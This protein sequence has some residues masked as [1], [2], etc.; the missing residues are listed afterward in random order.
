MHRSELR[1]WA[2]PDGR[3]FTVQAAP[4]PPTITSF[5][6]RTGS[7]GGGTVVAIT[8]TNFQNGATVK[9]GDASA[10][11][12][13]VNSATSINAISP[14]H[15]AGDVNLTVTNP[16]GQ[17][18]SSGT[19]TYTTPAPSVASVSPSSG[20]NAGGTG[21]TVTGSNFVSPTT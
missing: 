11:S 1:Y 19:F 4:T 7:T 10:V 6:P 9:F 5:T 13:T 3:T 17:T 15:A 12:T 16:D 8:G 20:S 2:R 21:I 18:V 14:V